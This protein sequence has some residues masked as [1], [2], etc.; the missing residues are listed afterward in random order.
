MSPSLS[1]VGTFLRVR[2]YGHVQQLSC[3]LRGSL[4]VLCE[5]VNLLP[6]A[7]HPL[8]HLTAMGARPRARRTHSPSAPGPLTVARARFRASCWFANPVSI[9]ANTCSSGRC[10]DTPSTYKQLRRPGADSLD[11]TF[12]HFWSLSVLPVQCFANHRLFAPN[13]IG[14][15][16][17]SC[18][19]IRTK[20]RCCLFL[21]Q[22]PLA[23]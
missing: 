1:M 13:A 19:E 20:G 16:T 11:A 4:V 8:V 10:S 12:S 2:S 15:R 23:S 22:P 3:V 7:D 21:A 17:T 14:V 18:P 9:A 5:R 6:G